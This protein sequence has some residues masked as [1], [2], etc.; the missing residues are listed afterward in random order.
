VIGIINYGSGNINS[1]ANIYHRLNIPYKIMSNPIDF[2]LADKLIL[3]GVGAF[4]ETMNLIDTYGMR[5]ELNELIKI[6]R[7]PILGICVG[8]QILA[9]SSDEGEAIGFGWIEGKVKQISK[10][11]IKQKPYLPHMGWNNILLSVNNHPLFKGIDTAKGF[12]FLHSYY[13]DAKREQDIFAK[14][15]YGNFFPCV[16]NND[17]VFGVQFHPEKS[18]NNGVRLFENYARI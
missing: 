5:E 4:D 11:S 8:M 2:K 13:F 14:V 9:S 10:V 16:I 18:H 6:K 1:I 15:G 12:Y 3:P 17:N 7:I